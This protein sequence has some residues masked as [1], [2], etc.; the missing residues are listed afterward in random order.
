MQADTVTSHGHAIFVRHTGRLA[1]QRSVTRNTDIRMHTI[2]RPLRATAT[3]FFLHGPNSINFAVVMLEAFQRFKQG[4][5]TNSIVQTLADNRVSNFFERPIENN[6]VANQNTVSHL[7]AS[8]TKIDEEFRDFRDF[9]LLGVARN[10]N[11]FSGG[12][13]N[14]RQI[15]LRC[16][17][18]HF[19]RKQIPS[20]EATDRIQTQI[21]SFVDVAD[22]E[23]I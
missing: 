14:A 6:H 13:H 11:R 21:T 3:D 18:T 1:A 15:T 12:V 4:P 17:D 5:A 19:A 22:E 20:I 10:M 7:V 23:S 8:Q 9:L 2:G 16:A